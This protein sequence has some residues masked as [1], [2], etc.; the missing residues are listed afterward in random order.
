MVFL[1]IEGFP[2]SKHL[3]GLVKVTS[4][5]AAAHAAF[6]SLAPGHVGSFVGKF[7]PILFHHGSYSE[8]FSFSFLKLLNVT[9]KNVTLY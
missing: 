3:L 2:V 8:A 1:K 5:L 9:P 6:A 7:G 4:A